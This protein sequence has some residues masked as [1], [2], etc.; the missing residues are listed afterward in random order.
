VAQQRSLMVHHA[1]ACCCGMQGVFLTF[2]KLSNGQN[3]L[4]RIRFNRQ[5][6][7]KAAASVW[8]QNNK[9]EMGLRYNIASNSGT[10]TGLH[11]PDSE[12]ATSAGLS[13]PHHRWVPA[14][15]KC[16]LPLTPFPAPKCNW[17]Q[18]DQK[19]CIGS[20]HRC[21]TNVLAISLVDFSMC[22][23]KPTSVIREARSSTHH[24]QHYTETHL[25]CCP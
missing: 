17:F 18:A 10:P 2:A 23:L 19:F 1:S 20:Q 5:H 13:P 16:C 7:D 3:S 25:I 14:P 12:P 15:Q 4:T 9:A 11:T 8:W 6:F 22:D 21:T 24:A